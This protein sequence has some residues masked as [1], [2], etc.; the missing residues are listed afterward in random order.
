MSGDEALVSVAAFVAGPLLWILWLLR[1]SRLPRFNRRRTA[2][3]VIAAALIVS[4]TILLIVLKTGASFDVVDAP[5]YLAMYVVLGLAWSRLTALTFPLL[6]VSLRDDVVER[7][8][9]AALLAVVGAILGVTLCY[10]GG[11]IGDGPGWW[12]VIFSAALAT[13]TLL[14]LWA[15]LNHLSPAA[16]SIA[17]D[18]DPAAGMRLGAFLLACGLVLGR[19]VAGDWDS[20]G[21]HRPRLPRRAAAGRGAAGPGHRRRA[22]VAADGAPP[23]RLLRSGSACSRRWSICSPRSDRCSLMGPER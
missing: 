19:G 10:A 13:A 11:N 15:A 17:I 5:S 3:T 7:R 21:R 4:A 14:M 9:T 12:V 20:G 16:D 8:N 23:A 2:V 1:M 22:R 18:R 6:G